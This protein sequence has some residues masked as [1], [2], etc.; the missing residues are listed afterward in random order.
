MCSFYIEVVVT[1]VISLFMVKFI[2]ML[3]RIELLVVV[4]IIYILWSKL[5][6]HEYILRYCNYFLLFFEDSYGLWGTEDWPFWDGFY[7]FSLYIY[8]Y[9]DQTSRLPFER[10]E[11]RY[12]RGATCKHYVYTSM[13][14]ISIFFFG[15]LLDFINN[16]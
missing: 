9:F 14:Y 7:I 10:M 2:P 16:I 4:Y 5:I 11:S 1:L 3:V 12:H 6:S 15:K 13:V 8:I